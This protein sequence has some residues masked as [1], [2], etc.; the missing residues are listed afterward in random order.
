M[1]AINVLNNSRRM[2]F[3]MAN[4]TRDWRGPARVGMC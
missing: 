1:E 3:P 2:S 4:N